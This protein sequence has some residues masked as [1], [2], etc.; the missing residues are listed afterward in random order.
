MKKVHQIAPD[1]KAF[2]LHKDIPFSVVNL[3]SLPENIKMP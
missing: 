1:L 2:Q 3:T